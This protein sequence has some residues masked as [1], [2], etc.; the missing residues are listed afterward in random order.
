MKKSILILAAAIS[1]IALLAAVAWALTVSSRVDTIQ[2]ANV[3]SV[4]VNNDIPFRIRFSAGGLDPGERAS[5]V[6]RRLGAMQN[7]KPEEITT[8]I[9]N[10]Q[11]VVMARNELVITAD[12]NHAAANNTSPQQLALLWRNNLRSAVGLQ[13]GGVPPVGAG[14]EPVNTARKVVPILSV[15]EGTRVGAAL[16]T[17][18]S[19]RVGD[20][21]A[22][23]QIE[24]DFK[25][26]ARVRALV[27]ID[28][29]SV[30]NIRRV[31]QTSVYA[32]GDYRL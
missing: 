31:P 20:V 1:T 16:V 9:V 15:G 6:A 5:V 19:D 24:G 3:G 8:G 22:V 30:T 21:K 26:N 28:A 11:Y 4:I 25:A 18:P 12:A 23:A 29:E 17:G 14:P 13:G 32:V 27:P 2:G 7:L 10:G